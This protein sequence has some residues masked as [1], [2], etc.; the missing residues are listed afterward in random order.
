[1]KSAP[2]FYLLCLLLFTIGIILLV[3]AIRILR[4]SFSGEVVAEIP[5]SQK[6]TEFE[7]TTPGVYAIW[8][9][10]PYIRKMPV[11]Q[12]KPV[13][14]DVS[15]GQEVRLENPLFRPNTKDFSTVKMEIFRFNAEAGR[16]RIEIA[17]GTGISEL[18]RIISNLVPAKRATPDQYFLL[19]RKSIPF[20]HT[21]LAIGLL[22]LS[23]FLI[24]GSVIFALPGSDPFTTIF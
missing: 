7:I 17:P 8:Q 15:S 12:F 13:L 3:K 18:E 21:L 10:G 14:F 16:Y 23:G 1:M 5:F 19:L 4:K 2:Y 11:D 22:V 20:F 6:K 24:L 9:K